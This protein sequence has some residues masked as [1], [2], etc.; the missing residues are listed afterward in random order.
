[1]S[2]VFCSDYAPRDTGGTGFEERHGK[3]RPCTACR[4]KSR[5]SVYIQSL[6]GTAC[7]ALCSVREIGQENDPSPILAI[8]P[9]SAKNMLC[10]TPVL[11]I[12]MPFPYCNRC[13][14][15]IS[16]MWASCWTP[17]TNLHWCKLHTKNHRCSSFAELFTGHCVYVNEGLVK[18]TGC[19]RWERNRAT[20]V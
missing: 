12:L 15:T 17:E 10:C 7:I 4:G 3:V 5:Q 6:L 19:I 8:L 13:V 20:A 14:T 18:D 16:N 1:M 11:S 9:S 2:L